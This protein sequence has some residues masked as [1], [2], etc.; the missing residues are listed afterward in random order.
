MAPPTVS[1]SKHHGGFLHLT[2]GTR[3]IEQLR[4]VL[5]GAKGTQ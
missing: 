2:A 5:P 1:V 3:L 4:D